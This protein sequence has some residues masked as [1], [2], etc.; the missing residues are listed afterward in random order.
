[1]RASSALATAVDLFRTPA[2]APALR[3]RPLPADV[4]AVIEIAAGSDTATKTAA[5]DLRV[6][7]ATLRAAAEFYL[8]QVLFF[9]EADAW[10][11]LGAVPGASRPQLRDHMRG[12]MLWLHPDHNKHEWQALNAQRVMAA[13]RALSTNTTAASNPPPALRRV[14]GGSPQPLRRGGTA[15]RYRPSWVRQPLA[16]QPRHHSTKLLRRVIAAGTLSFILFVPS[17]SPTE[18]AGAQP[19]VIA[20]SQ[21]LGEAEPSA[22]VVP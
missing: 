12:L 17:S 22:Q 14:G 15:I 9:K 20:A 11:V 10:R 16:H 8:L 2:L 7:S 18:P 19:P 4:L 13:W 6:S 21:P 5:E 1:M 3:R